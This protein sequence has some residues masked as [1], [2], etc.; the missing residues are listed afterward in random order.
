M[1]DGRYKE[2]ERRRKRRGKKQVGKGERWAEERQRR[3]RGRGMWVE[4]R[5][6]KSGERTPIWWRPPLSHGNCEIYF[7][8]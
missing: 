2:V 5:V 4:E 1:K 7:K 3:D 8:S 6:R